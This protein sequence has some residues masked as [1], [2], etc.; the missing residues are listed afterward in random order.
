MSLAVCS[1]CGFEMFIPHC[2]SEKNYVG[3]CAPCLY[4]TSEINEN[5]CRLCDTNIAS[6]IYHLKRKLNAIKNINL[7][8]KPY[9]HLAVALESQLIPLL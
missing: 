2:A 1:T 4:S 7:S 6:T 5:S 8:G 3:I 9:T